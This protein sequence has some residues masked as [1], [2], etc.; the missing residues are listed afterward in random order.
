MSNNLSLLLGIKLYQLPI[1]YVEI[2]NT[3]LNTEEEEI[4]ETIYIIKLPQ[5]GN[6]NSTPVF[7]LASNL[8]S[9]FF[10]QTII[11]DKDN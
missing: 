4:L 2:E 7:Y 8:G 10:V 5:Y 1:Y 3:V 9:N 11:E 6:D